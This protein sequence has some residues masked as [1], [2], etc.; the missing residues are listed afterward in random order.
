MSSNPPYIITIDGTSSSGKS[1]ISRLLAKKLNF[2]LL[3]SGKLYRSVGYIA[4]DIYE[5]IDIIKDYSE[6]VSKIS[7]KPNNVSHEYEV[8][9]KNKI[10]DSLLYN[11]NIGIA[12]SIVSKVPE[13]RKSMYDLQHSCVN[14]NGL[15]ANGRD[16]GSEVFTDARLKI[17]IT[18]DIDI[19]ARRRYEELI[20]KGDIVQYQDIYNSLK[21]RDDSD[22]N[23][24]ISPLKVPDNAHILDTSN[25]KPNA[26]VDKI[27]NL[28]TITSI[29]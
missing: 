26:I 3:D 7:L 15:I 25:L 18:A 12:A 16:M 27:L 20:N 17:Y 9:Y 19:R 28:Y 8:H 10:I 14:G 4:C 24:D 23:R 6:L 13:V 22:M 5:S 29:N 11:E 21:K 2:K 1:T